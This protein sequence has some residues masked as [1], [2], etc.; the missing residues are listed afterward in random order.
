V[1]ATVR[2]AERLEGE[3]HV[4]GDKSISHRALILGS[5]AEGWSRIRGLSN[6]AD[7]QSTAACLR[8]LDVEVEESA[9]RGMGLDGLRKAPGVLNCGNSGT[10]M[11]L[12]AGLL[13][14]Q[15]FVS[16]LHGDESLA[17][18]P[19][20]RVVAPLREMGANA[21]WPPLRVGGRVP[22]H[23]IEYK[24]PIAS[25]QVKSAILIAGLF[26]EGTTTVIE[27]VATRDHTELMLGSMG[28]NVSVAGT[29]VAIE[30]A[31]RLQ[32]LD[33]EVPGDVS[34]ASF[35]LVAGALVPNSRIRILGSGVNPTRTAFVQVLRRCGFNIETTQERLIASEPVA[36][37][38]VRS[39][40]DLQS[41]KVTGAMAAEMIDELLVLAVA[42][43]QLPGD[44]VI[45]GARELHVKESDRI[46]AMAEGLAA[47]GADIT[48]TDDGWAIKGP[49]RLEG[50]RVQS[51][52]DHR[53]AMALAVAG[54]LAGGATEIEDAD[55][56]A[57]SYPDFFDQ[58][59]SL[60]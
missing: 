45:A 44:S 8:A 16:E 33:L 14:G 5:L 57:I 38:E 11:R 28:A 39:S 35:W 13:A 4:P 9:V 15:D 41:L 34:A 20:D 12:L 10:T 52:G 17:R 51:H 40:T 56:V 55:C 48:A 27:P 54:L 25:A 50:A 31:A 60:C 32:P 30:K 3:V 59:E 49:S 22:L 23:G 37:L 47:M 24:T 46:A 29:R 43:T 18:R 1:I 19:M 6:G 7:V 53:V 21:D 42:A 2:K 58:L 36:D 26:A